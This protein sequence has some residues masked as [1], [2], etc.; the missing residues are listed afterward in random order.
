MFRQRCLYVENDPFFIYNL[1]KQQNQSRILKDNT[2]DGQTPDSK[3]FGWSWSR[4]RLLRVGS[5][6]QFWVS[7]GSHFWVGSTFHWK[8][9]ASSQ[10]SPKV[11]SLRYKLYTFLHCYLW[12]FTYC[13]FIGLLRQIPLKI[14]KFV[15]L[16][17]E[18]SAG[19]V[20]SPQRWFFSNKYYACSTV[21]VLFIARFSAWYDVFDA[22]Q[23]FSQMR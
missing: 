22:S 20:L 5:C 10:F 4:S 2:S 1:I 17:P 3:I 21:G 19:S 7:S 23:L 16:P 13:N 12:L 6:F 8:T 14:L 9:V 18:P 11:D 15:Q